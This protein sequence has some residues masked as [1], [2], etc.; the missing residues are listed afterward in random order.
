MYKSIRNGSVIQPIIIKREGIISIFFSGCIAISDSF[1]NFV[2]G[3]S[4]E[5][6]QK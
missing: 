5:F 6:V 1:I 2:I 3:C 4:D